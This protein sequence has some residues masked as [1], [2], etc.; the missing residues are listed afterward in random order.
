MKAHKHNSGT[1]ILDSHE[2]LLRKTSPIQSSS[3]ETTLDGLLADI[4]VVA[5]AESSGDDT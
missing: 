4:Q 1:S 5:G 2:Q 3:T